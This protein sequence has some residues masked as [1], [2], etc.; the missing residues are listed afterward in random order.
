M[1][2]LSPTW[3][4]G[5]QRNADCITHE[6]YS[7]CCE[8]PGRLFF[9][10]GGQHIITSLCRSSPNC[11]RPRPQPRR[12]AGWCSRRQ[13]VRIDHAA[14]VHNPARGDPRAAG[15]QLQSKVHHVPVRPITLDQRGLP[16]LS[17]RSHF[18]Q[19]SRDDV[20]RVVA[21]QDRGGPFIIVIPAASTL[22][23]SRRPWQ[24][25]QKRSD[26]AMRASKIN[27]DC[28]RLYAQAMALLH[29]FPR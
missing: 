15:C 3:Q 17:R 1:T 16:V 26:K 5:L 13:A 20:P 24:G 29:T 7:S 28:D 9:C 10:G 4:V 6:S 23:I 12:P 25:F 14:K 22:A 27:R 18:V 19:A 2:S 11:F 21:Q 8:Q